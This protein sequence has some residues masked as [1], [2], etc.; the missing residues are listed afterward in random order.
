MKKSYSGIYKWYNPQA[1]ISAFK[2][3]INILL[4]KLAN[5]LLVLKAQALPGN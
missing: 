4:K 1:A 3:K 2:L 5:F